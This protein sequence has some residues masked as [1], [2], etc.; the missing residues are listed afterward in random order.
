MGQTEILQLNSNTELRPITAPQPQAI[1]GVR[2]RKITS[3]SNLIA[4]LK[5]KIQKSR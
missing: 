1:Y 2:G 4:A 3:K 5:S